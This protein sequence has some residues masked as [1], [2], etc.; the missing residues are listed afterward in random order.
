MENQNRKFSTA[1]LVLSVSCALL[2]G[3]I[4]GYFTSN[5]MMFRNIVS[6][7][8]SPTFTSIPHEKRS[9]LRKDI[10]YYNPG[11]DEL[12]KDS[13]KEIPKGNGLIKGKI[14][15]DDKPA[16]G[17]EI[18]FIL[19]SGQ[20][21]QKTVVDK[22]GFYE[23]HIPK[24][25]Y[26]FN[27]LIIH[28]KNDFLNDKF[29]INRV[30]LEEG[31][32]MTLD[33]AKNQNIQKEYS[34][35]EKKYGAKKA[36]EELLKNFTASSGFKDRFSFE[37]VDKPLDFPVFHYRDPIRILSPVENSTIN[38]ADLKF[39]WSPIENAAYYKLHISRIDKKGSTTSYYP[40]ISHDNIRENQISYNEL[41]KSRPTTESKNKC[42]TL[43]TLEPRKIY[44]V[45]IIAYNKDNQIITASSLSTTELLLFSIKNR[46]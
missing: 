35:L 5:F 23:I 25:K 12:W 22:S 19:A 9:D 24:G 13:Y 1:I 44:G 15:I 28:N 7:D 8:Q 34:E 6:F 31:I 17:L 45:K 46:P 26:Y 21:T 37:V 27:G 3:F 38:L 29:L 36:T 10:V 39:I 11:N 43:E 40:V 30:A 20:K 41:L 4:I 18:S 33:N 42:D 2:I 16:M 32:S 14:F